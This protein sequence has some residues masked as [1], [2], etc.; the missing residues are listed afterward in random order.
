MAK[1]IVQLH[2]TAPSGAKCDFVTLTPFPNADGSGIVYLIEFQE[3]DFEEKF[4][5]GQC[6]LTAGYVRFLEYDKSK[7]QGVTHV[8]LRLLAD[9]I[10]QNLEP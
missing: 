10:Q 8:G 9:W 1:N 5:V 7:P 2:A 6:E 4:A 3:L